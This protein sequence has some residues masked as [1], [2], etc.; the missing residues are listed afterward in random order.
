MSLNPTNIEWPRN[1][2]LLSP[3]L[4]PKLASS[5]GKGCTWNPITGCLN[6]C[7]YCY[8]RRLANTRLKDRYLVNANLASRYLNPPYAYTADLLNPFYPRFWPERLR[9]IGKPNDYGFSQVKKPKGIFVCDMSDLFGIGIPDEWTEQ[10]L[11]EIMRWPEHRFYLLT[12]QYQ[13]L[14]K[15]SPFPDNCFVGVSVTTN[16]DMTRAL[17]NLT[18]IEAKTKYI[19]FEPLLGQIGMTDH[20]KIKGLIDQ[21]IIGAMT[22]T[23]ESMKPLLLKY[24]ALIP[25]PY[26]KKLTLQPRIEWVE[27]IVGSADKAGVAVF[28]KDNLNSI[29]GDPR[30]NFNLFNHFEPMAPTLRQEMPI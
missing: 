26:G 2:V 29:L 16:G 1:P 20:M 9:D 15:F 22:G 30:E 3:N 8:A 14:V 11:G 6:D 23:Y 7:P 13:N 25:M 18:C 27:E 28:L 24:P 19:S 21:V 4:D 17:V 12:K 5:Y 10:V